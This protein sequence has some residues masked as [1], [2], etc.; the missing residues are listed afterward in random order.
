[1]KI[2]RIA[3]HGLFDR[4]DHELTFDPCERITIMIG[5]NGYGKTTILRILNVLFNHSPRSLGRM[6]FA[7]LLVDF[8]DG[9]RLTVIRVPDES[10]P[11]LSYITSTQ[12]TE[13]YI[14][15]PL[16]TSQ[17]VSF[18]LGIIED[19]I[20]GLERIGLQSGE[21]STPMMFSI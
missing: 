5:P 19:I 4:F 17:G 3:V 7:K 10:S 12:E 20:P 2:S 6:P 18:P 13:S 8:D 9:S 15:E 16:N 1:M 21:M 11:R 14:P